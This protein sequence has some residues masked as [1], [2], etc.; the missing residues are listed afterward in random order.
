MEFLSSSG[1]SILS[2]SSSKECL[3]S[4][5]CLPVDICICLSQLLGRVSEEWFASLMSASLI[6]WGINTC[7]WDA[8]Q[9]EPVAVDSSLSLCSMFVPGVLWDRSNFAS[10]VCKWV[11]IPIP[12]LGGCPATGGRL[13]KFHIPKVGH[14]AKFTCTD[15][16]SC[17]SGIS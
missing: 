10:K 13:F 4:L 9:N 5:Q 14:F 17:V 6:V 16:S 15:F 2:A 8:C 7:P 1:P 3:T 12:P 11:S